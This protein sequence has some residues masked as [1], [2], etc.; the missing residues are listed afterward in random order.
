VRRQ[1][2]TAALLTLLVLALTACGGGNEDEDQISDVIEKTA[3]TNADSNCDKLETQSFLEQTNFSTGESAVKS[4]KASGPEGNAK[5]VEVSDVEVDGDRA[6]AHVALTGSA[7]DGQTLVV[8]LAKQGDQWKMDH[9][10]D[11]VD[12]D[13]KRFGEAFAAGASKGGDLDQTQAKCVA[14][15][16]GSQKP[17]AL[18]AAVLSGDPNRIG[19]AFRGCLIG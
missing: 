9:I 13:V 14:A 16:F 11:I 4:C 12:F 2:L 8:S 15:Y 5:S 6:T 10:D 7:F 18:K 1:V 19:P 17:A 3:T